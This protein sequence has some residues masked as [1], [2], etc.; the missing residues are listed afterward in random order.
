[1]VISKGV[2]IVGPW[3]MSEVWVTGLAWSMVILNFLVALLI[4]AL[5]LA[6]EYRPPLKDDAEVELVVPWD[7]LDSPNAVQL[8]LFVMKTTVHLM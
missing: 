1:M 2:R 5:R 4:L 7:E 6:K 8:F 3:H